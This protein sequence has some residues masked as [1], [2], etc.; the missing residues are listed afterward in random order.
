MKFTLKTSKNRNTSINH[1]VPSQ[2][3][4]F[5]CKEMT[6]LTYHSIRTINSFK[7]IQGSNLKDNHLLTRQTV[8]AT[9]SNHKPNRN[10]F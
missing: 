6:Q 8:I 10:K 1:Q 4:N 2:N 9:F 7:N 3:P 5:H